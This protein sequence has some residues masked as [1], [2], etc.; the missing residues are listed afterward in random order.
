[1]PNI[2]NAPG[3]PPLS[4]YSSGG[5][6]QLSGDAPGISPSSAPPVWGIF[7]QQG[8]PVIVADNVTAFEYDE[9][10]RVAKFPIE[11]GAFAG[12]N[13]VVVPF[14]AIVSFTKG[15]PVAERTA[16]LQSVS[17]AKASLDLYVIMTPE[18]PYQNVNVVRDVIK[19][20]TSRNGV[21]LI[22]VDVYCEE[23]RPAGGPAFGSN[24]QQPQS[25]AQANDGTVQPGTVTLG[26]PTVS[27]PG[28]SSSGGTGNITIP[29]PGA[30]GP[31][32]SSG[33]TG[34]IT[35]PFP[36]AR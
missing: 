5:E 36:P 12:Y 2:P 34:E 21:Q 26:Q 23:I 8:N 4:S 16:F 10:S 17:A 27:Q 3:V 25:A 1:M 20:R 30:T 24:V 14:H 22:A 11:Q 18:I 29:Y 35:M 19:R 9:E 31:F 33:G 6:A 15:G 13:K 32:S 7:D 28:A